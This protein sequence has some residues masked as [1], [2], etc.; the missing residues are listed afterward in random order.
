ML[1]QRSSAKCIFVTSTT[2][3][4]K[5]GVKNQ[6]L[7]R[8]DLACFGVKFL[9]TSVKKITNMRYGPLVI[10]QKQ[11]RDYN[12]PSKVNIFN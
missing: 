4:F 7:T 10:Y 12:A 6:D 2:R 3:I 1:C 8:F 11:H 9:A 5:P